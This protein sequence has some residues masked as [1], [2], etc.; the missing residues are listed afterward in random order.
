GGNA[1]NDFKRNRA[2]RWTEARGGEV[3]GMLPNDDP[4]AG[5][6]AFAVSDDGK[7]VGGASGAEARDAFIWTRA[8]GMFKVQ[9]YLIQLGVPGLD[10]WVL[11]T[12]L[13]IS[14]DGT[15]IAGWGY[16]GPQHF[17]RVQGWVIS[18]LPPFVD[19]DDDTILDAVDNCTLLPNADQRDTD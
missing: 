9:D 6:Y 16:R 14:S 10:D 3:I 13:A 8:T 11:D 19:T 5:A 4:L 2:F 17:Q 1:G 7:V 18:G 12:V 15:T